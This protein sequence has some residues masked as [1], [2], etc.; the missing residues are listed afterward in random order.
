MKE[1][2]SEPTTAQNF[3]SFVVLISFSSCFTEGTPAN[4]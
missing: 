1:Y 4:V 3:P 2:G